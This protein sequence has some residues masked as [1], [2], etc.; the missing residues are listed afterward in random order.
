[1]SF[2]PAGYVDKST[3]NLKDD[4]LVNDDAVV[5]D[6][7]RFPGLPFIKVE[8]IKKEETTKEELKEVNKKCLL[9]VIMRVKFSVLNK[10]ENNQHG[11]ALS[12]FFSFIFSGWQNPLDS[13]EN[14][15]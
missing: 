10:S 2:A 12:L 11:V 4:T 6:C 9:H 13:G 15:Y 3:N 1:M 14:H 7:H 8:S 5:G